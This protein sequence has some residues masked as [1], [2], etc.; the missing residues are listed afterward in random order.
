MSNVSSSENSIHPLS[1]KF[2]QVNLVGH[3]FGGSCI[4][5]AME[6]YP[7]KIAK[8]IFVAAFMVKNGQAALDLFSSHG[9]C[10]ISMPRDTSPSSSFF[11]T[12]RLNMKDVYLH[13][14]KN[15]YRLQVQMSFCVIRKCLCMLM[16]KLIL[17]LL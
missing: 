14:K 7:H 1:L 4:S 3:N 5:Y 17:P 16:V 8:A 6:H 11:N 10:T 2:S 9:V 13:I 15:I 12:L